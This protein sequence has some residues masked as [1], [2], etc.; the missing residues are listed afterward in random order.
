[1]GE[2]VSAALADDNVIEQLNA[3]DFAGPVD[4]F[5]QGDVVLARGW[6][7]RGVIIVDDNRGRRNRSESMVRCA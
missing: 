3:Q 7:A 6:L 1:V 5:G 2:A 4:S